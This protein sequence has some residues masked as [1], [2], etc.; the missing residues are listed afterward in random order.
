MDTIWTPDFNI[1]EH[2]FLSFLNFLLLQTSQPL[3]GIFDFSYS[4][5]GVLPK[6]EIFI[7]ML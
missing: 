7:V 3:L 5:V 2:S 1:N 4:E 6:S